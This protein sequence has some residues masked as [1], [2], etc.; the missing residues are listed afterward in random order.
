LRIPPETGT[1]PNR[2][3]VAAVVMRLLLRGRPGVGKTTVARRLVQLLADA[4]IP[5][6]GFT[7]EE[8]RKGRQRVGFAVES[9]SGQRGVLAHVRCAG[10]PR[11]GRYGVDLSTFERIALPA[12]VAPRNG[13]VVID[14]LGKMEIASAPFRDA[15]S[16]LF[17]RGASIVAMVHVFPHPFTDALTRRPDVE[18]RD[19]TRDNRDTLPAELAT[20]IVASVA[21][22]RP[23][24]L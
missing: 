22:T 24:V 4:Q 17:D 6:A 9:V 19:V 12:L 10:P 5:V 7:T 3:I 18:T 23:E 14:E 2:N 13:V 8:I 11:V 21:P 1:R 20:L 16:T 15:V